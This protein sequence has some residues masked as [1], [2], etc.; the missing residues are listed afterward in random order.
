MKRT[1]TTFKLLLGSLAITLSFGSVP[2]HASAADTAFINQMSDQ[3][4]A[5]EKKTSGYI[6]GLSPE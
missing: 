5:F 2:R 6:Q 3:Y 4:H 1:S